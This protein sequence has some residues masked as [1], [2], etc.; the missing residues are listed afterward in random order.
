[1]TYLSTLEG[2]LAAT[3]IPASRRR[4]IVAEFADHL[5]EDP[6]AQLGSP[7]DLARQFADELGT[8][9][10]RRAAIVAFAGLAVVGIAI[11]ALVLL[12]T[13]IVLLPAGVHQVGSIA[14]SSSPTVPLFVVASQVAFAAGVLAILR[15]WRLRRAPVITAAD[16]AILYRRAGLGLFAGIL[17]VASAPIGGIIGHRGWV[18]VRTVDIA[19]PCVLLLMVI[20]LF[21]LPLS[22]L[23]P[24]GRGRAADLTFDLGIR[25]PRVTPWR[26]AAALS[27]AILLVVALA[28]VVADD[29]Y[30]GIARGLADGMACLAG[31]MVLGRY[32]GL[33][34]TRE[35][36]Q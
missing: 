20:A 31:F 8:R 22:R 3:G 14:D 35:S 11:V 27:A 28:G 5:H 6:G 21:M 7:R 15:A 12:G 23:R 33:R 16:A 10:A 25:D 9:L 26:V 4:R 2:E 29:P 19:G 1:M 18:A 36:A 24:T 32:L 30:D 34:T 13:R 17:S